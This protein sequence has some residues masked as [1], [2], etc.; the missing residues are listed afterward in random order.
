MVAHVAVGRAQAL[1]DREA[2]PLVMVAAGVVVAAHVE[3]RDVFKTTASIHVE[4]GLVGALDRAGVAQGA[5]RGVVEVLVDAADTLVEVE[6][7]R[8][9]DRSR[10]QRSETILEANVVEGPQAKS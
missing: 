6:K 1:A 2:I 7:L 5:A 3:H 10:V 4:T 9:G 8:R